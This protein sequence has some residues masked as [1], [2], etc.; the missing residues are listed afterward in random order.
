MPRAVVFDFDGLITDTETAE[1]QS[2]QRVYADHRAEL[3]RALWQTAIGTEGAFDPY[4]DLAERTGR[5]IDRDA[6]REQCHEYLRPLL[7]ALEPLPGVLDWIDAA[8]REGLAV[9]IASSSPASWVDRGLDTLGLSDRFS[10]R[11]TRDQVKRA[12]PS[13]ELYELALE[14]LGVSAGEAVAL[15]DSPHGVEAATRAGLFC[16]AV[17]GPMTRDMSFEAADL[18][19]ASLVDAPLER[20]RALV[21]AR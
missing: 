10:V 14:R 11:A 3:P 20:V 19:V 15:E 5:A 7:A 16:V 17:P 13:P 21:R 9:A 18:V 4:R 2:W 12:K 6:V 8:Q 1:F